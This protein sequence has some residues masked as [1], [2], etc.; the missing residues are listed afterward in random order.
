MLTLVL[1]LVSVF[2][3]RVYEAK[4]TITLDTTSAVLTMSELRLATTKLEEYAVLKVADSVQELRH[5]TDSTALASMSVA[6]KTQV[7]ATDSTRAA[8]HSSDSARGACVAD[9]AV[10]E[11]KAKAK[12]W[13]GLGFGAGGGLVLSV[14]TFVVGFI[15][16]SR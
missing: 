5:V 10:I 8:L 14:V 2:G 6:Y 13:T 11:R 1:A 12:F 9:A 7:Q 3:V 4:S 15:A 16:A